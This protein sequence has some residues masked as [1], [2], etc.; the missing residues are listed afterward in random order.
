VFN[1]A[2]NAHIVWLPES[3][4]FF[5]L[6]TGII[7][8]YDSISRNM[9]VRDVPHGQGY[10]LPKGGKELYDYLHEQFGSGQLTKYD[11]NDK[12]I[13]GADSNTTT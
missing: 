9:W 3:D 12:V 2:T 8:T 10:N 6:D 11:E 5:N 4:V 1:S 7:Y 13:N